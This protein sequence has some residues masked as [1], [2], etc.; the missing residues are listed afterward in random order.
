QV[1]QFMHWMAAR[2]SV[3]LIR[4][5]REQGEAARRH[6]LER[7]LRLLQKGDDPRQVL[8]ALS[9][10]LTNKLLHG[11]TQ[12]LNEAQAEERAA[13]AALIERLYRSQ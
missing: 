1:G 10:G 5:L 4:Q 9:Q 7:A 12:A 8:E 2:A 13:L 11:P 3:P 6:E